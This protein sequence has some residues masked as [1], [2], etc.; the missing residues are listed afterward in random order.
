[1]QASTSGDS[2]AVF[3]ITVLV[4]LASWCTIPFL[5][6]LASG[7]LCLSKRF[8]RQS[9]PYGETKTAGPLFY[10]I[11]MRGWIH[12]SGGV[13]L[14][15][16]SDALYASVLFLLRV[17]HPPLR[18]PWSEIRFGQTTF[19]FRSYIVLKLG[20][21]EKIPMRISRRMAGKLG[22]LGRVQSDSEVTS[23]GSLASN[24]PTPLC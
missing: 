11:Y 24:K 15:A 23:P 22:I 7:W 21:E 3:V 12:Y 14:T 2:V 17:G 9:E 1:M 18:I 10:T 19:F 20:T 5:I 8:R 4:L 16:A 13:R 6:S